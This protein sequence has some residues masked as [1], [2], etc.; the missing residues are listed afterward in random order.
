MYITTSM[1]YAG[2]VVTNDDVTVVHNHREWKN[3]ECLEHFTSISLLEAEGPQIAG[4]NP[5]LCLV[6]PVFPSMKTTSF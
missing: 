5:V 3:V 4:K 2:A 6:S 1:N